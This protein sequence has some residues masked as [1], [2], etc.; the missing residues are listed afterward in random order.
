MTGE[1]D[2]GILENLKSASKNRCFVIVRRFLKNVS[3]HTKY[4]LRQF[5]RFNLWI[6][7]AACLMDETLP[8]HP[9]QLH[10]VNLL[11]VMHAVFVGPVSL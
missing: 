6:R 8:S 9:T 5:T 10:H 7:S 2:R 11:L 3:L 4:M 1:I